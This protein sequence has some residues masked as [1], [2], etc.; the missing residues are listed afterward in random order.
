MPLGFVLHSVWWS[1]GM[2]WVAFA[3][4]W[5]W[6]AWE[7]V[8]SIPQSYRSIPVVWPWTCL[9]PRISTLIGKLDIPPLWGTYGGSYMLWSFLNGPLNLVTY[10]IALSTR[11]WILVGMVQPSPLSCRVGPCGLAI[12]WLRRSF[13]FLGHLLIFVNKATQFILQHPFL[14]WGLFCLHWALLHLVDHCDLVQRP[15]Y[16]LGF[17][18]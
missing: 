8:W 18:I 16:R 1:G 7:I 4:S 12:G 14:G 10:C 13:H 15:R 17:F 2:S 3:S 5:L 6:I 11:P 9:L